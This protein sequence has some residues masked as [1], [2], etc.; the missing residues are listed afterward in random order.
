MTRTLHVVTVFVGP[1]GRGGNHLGVFL[2]AADLPA[3]ERQ[4]IAA[5][6]GYAETVFL[7]DAARGALWIHTPATELRLAGH[8]LVG[9][10][11]LLAELGQP[12]PVLRPPAGDVP[13]WVADDRTWIRADPNN[14]PEFEL[15]RLASAAEVDAHPG[16]AGPDELLQIWAWE[17]E[18]RVRVR[19]FPTRMG[20][21]EDEAT[22]AAALRLGAQLGQPL[23]IRQGVG[24]QILVNP[25]PDGTIEI[26][27]TVAAVETREYPA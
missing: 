25:G 5:D 11:W 22:G 16:A 27:G 10:A 2:D 21:T 18:G 17:G 13:T 8:P 15:H 9:T 4:R 20:I 24:S 12:V 6:L 23:V 14:A 26:G 19:V 1:D 3:D 7:S